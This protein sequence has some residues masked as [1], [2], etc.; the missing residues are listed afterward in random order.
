[1]NVAKT[2]SECN[3]TDERHYANNAK[4][5]FR[6]INES[7]AITAI[8]HLALIWHNKFGK[9]YTTGSPLYIKQWIGNYSSGNRL[10]L[11][12]KLFSD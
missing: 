5:A 7:L 1:M 8:H 3:T 4:S 6:K 9:L 10:C 2:N 11:N 12:K